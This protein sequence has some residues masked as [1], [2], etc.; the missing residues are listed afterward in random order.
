[1][2]E[3]CATAA[4]PKGPRCRGSEG[5]STSR[6]IGRGDPAPPTSCK[7]VAKA[8]I[9]SGTDSTRVS[10]CFAL[11]LSSSFIREYED[12]TTLSA[13]NYLLIKNIKST[14]PASSLR[15]PRRTVKRYKSRVPL[16]P[17]Y[18]NRSC[19]RL[20]AILGATPPLGLT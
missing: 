12:S 9:S 5:A 17:I 2:D 15:N 19:R 11:T 18:L 20:L 6:K 1:M 16:E 4:G 10:F 13:N 8:S 7:E 3:T 14:G